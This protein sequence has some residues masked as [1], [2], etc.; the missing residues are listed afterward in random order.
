M[1]RRK[2]RPVETV[3]PRAPPGGKLTIKEDVQRRVEIIVAAPMIR[4]VVNIPNEFIL[5]PKQPIDVVVVAGS[6]GDG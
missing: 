5:R 2:C 3:D 4:L 6:P 1:D